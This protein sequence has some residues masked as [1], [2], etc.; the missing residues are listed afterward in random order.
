MVLEKVSLKK[1]DPYGAI[2]ISNILKIPSYEFLYLG[3]TGVDMI[4]A[5]RAGMYPIGVLW[6]FRTQKELLEN[7]AK[8]LIKSPE[9]L[10]DLI[11]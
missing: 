2:E 5:N 3:D 7:G 1:P 4:T 10:L 8:I 9:E 11:S 6:G